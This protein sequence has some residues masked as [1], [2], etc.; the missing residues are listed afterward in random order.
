VSRE[1][2][3]TE[4]IFE[5]ANDGDRQAV[6]IIQTAARALGKNVAQMINLFD[7]AAVV[8]GGGLGLAPGLFRDTLIESA[9]RQIWHVPVQD[10]P[11][12]PAELG[13]L[14]GLVGAAMCCEKDS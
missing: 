4:E 10:L 5:A 3:R 6:E 1:I 11:I 8:L 7:P 9:R 2:G 14:A 13:T 12:V